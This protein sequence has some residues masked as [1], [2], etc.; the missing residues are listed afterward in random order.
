MSL[1][2]MDGVEMNEKF[3]DTFEIPSNERKQMVESGWYCKI[4]VYCADGN[5]ERIWVQVTGHQNGKFIGTLANDPVLFPLKYEDV[6]EFSPCNILAI[7]S[8]QQGEGE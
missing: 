8:P 1:K 7:L 6:V 2:L 3:P 5:T 4:G